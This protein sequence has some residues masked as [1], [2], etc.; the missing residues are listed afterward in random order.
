MQLLETIDI[1][2][3][4]R[5]RITLAQG[6]LT[7]LSPAGAVDVL[8]VSAFRGDYSPTPGS[9][10]G[11]LDRKGLSVAK[12]A[13][14]KDI[15][16]LES[17]SCW[18][19]HEFTA[20]DSGMPYRRVLCFEPH[21]LRRPPEVVGDIFRALAPILAVRPDIKSLAMPVLAAGD[22]G[23][24]AP[25]M[26]GPLLDAALNWLENDL[27]VDRLTIVTR[28]DTTTEEAR[29][30]FLVKKAAYERAAPSPGVEGFDYDVFISYSHANASECEA[31]E[32]SLRE[33]RPGI[34]IFVDRHEIDVGASWQLK[35]FE[36]LERSRKVVAL[37]SPAYLASTVCKEEFGIAWIVGRKTMRTN[38][39]PLYVYTAGLPAYMTYQNYLDCR[40]GER[41]KIAEASQRLLADL[42]RDGSSA[43]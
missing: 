25:E 26:L 41:T 38:L 21:R 4:Q 33:A 1:R 16:L 18:L 3:G 39:F 28:G 32:Q 22:Q 43:I 23:Y 15:D 13:L 11:A 5:G 2:G 17:Y 12:L 34:R 37:L 6:D 20:A 8:V 29:R 42:D 40:E 36:S 31:L 14:D 19:S 27:P 24:P 10:I 30:I 7:E 35:I 9:L